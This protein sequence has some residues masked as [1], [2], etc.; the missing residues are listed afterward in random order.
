MVV[1]VGKENLRFIVDTGSEEVLLTRQAQQ[2]LHL[3]VHLLGQNAK[4]SIFQGKI[5][6]LSLGTIALHSVPFTTYDNQDAGNIDHWN[7]EHPDLRVDGLIGM[8]VLRTLAIGID[9]HRN[10]MQ[11]WNRGKLSQ[12]A[13]E[14]FLTGPL[15]NSTPAP[16]RQIPIVLTTAG[17]EVPVQVGSVR[18]RLLVDT[19]A[20]TNLAGS[21]LAPYLHP[22]T[23]SHVG[24]FAGVLGSTP[25][26]FYAIP[27]LTLGSE[28]FACPWFMVAD[29][30]DQ[31]QVCGILGMSLFAESGCILD[32]P[33]RKLFFV[34]ATTATSAARAKLSQLGIVPLGGQEGVI[35][36]LFA[37]TAKS[38]GLQ[39]QDV[40]I[41]IDHK[42]L[43]QIADLNLADR[44]TGNVTFTMLSR[45]NGSVVR[46]DLDFSLAAL[47]KAAS[48]PLPAGEEISLLPNEPVIYH[49]PYGALYVPA[50]YKGPVDRTGKDAALPT[51]TGGYLLPNK[52][53]DG[54]A[55]HIRI[56]ASTVQDNGGIVY[57]TEPSQPVEIPSDGYWKE[58]LNGPAKSAFLVVNP[59]K[60]KKLPSDAKDR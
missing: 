19:G 33:G 40:V 52:G 37:E 6:D 22:L 47:Q 31:K 1:P 54:T 10:R 30:V 4:L 41:L 23:D 12:T 60:Q 49:F 42:P 39:P 11:F 21:R 32:L 56:K 25:T 59:L 43:D 24:T 17:V 8:A 48:M 18:T 29:I 34:R 57:P 45:E 35:G 50:N 55:S 15:E 36:F 9:L 38:A 20:R 13:A 58:R 16:V 28:V 27:S 7:R 2:S 44:A 3:P 53:P 51:P 5:P 14:Q 46:K 26:S